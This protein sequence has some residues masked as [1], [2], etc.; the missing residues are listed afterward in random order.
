MTIVGRP[1]NLLDGVVNAVIIAVMIWVGTATVQQSQVQAGQTAS[2][3]H[4]K[5]HL[6]RIEA[7]IDETPT[8]EGVRVIVRQE[9]AELE[10]RVRDLEMNR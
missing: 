7:R 6:L 4:I 5:A 8:E 9:L 3:D 2:L 1:K 10:R